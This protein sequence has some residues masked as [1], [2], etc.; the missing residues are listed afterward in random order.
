MKMLI[1]DNCCAQIIHVS[2][3]IALPMSRHLSSVEVQPLFYA[4]CSLATA[5]SDIR[6]GLATYNTIGFQS[7][8]TLDMKYREISLK[9][10]AFCSDIWCAICLFCPQM[11]LWQCTGV[12][13]CLTAHQH[14]IVYLVAL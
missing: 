10:A 4:L 1:I 3:H 6:D 14:N 13:S 2:G 9:L 8:H 11:L 7:V 12:S 5:T